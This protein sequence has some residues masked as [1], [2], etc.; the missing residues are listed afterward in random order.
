MVAGP[1]DNRLTAGQ[2]RPP[3]ASGAVTA[4]REILRLAL[5]Y[6]AAGWPV[7][8]CRPDDPSC[9]GGKDCECKAPLTE[10]GCL[11]ASTGPQV[12]RAWWRRWPAANVAIATGAP[13]PDVL[14]VD[15][16]PD[17][18]GWPAFNCLKRAGLL[19][20]A[21]A[22]VRTPSGGLH[23]Y[24]AGTS[25]RNGKLARHHLDFRSAG[26]YVL[27]PPSRVHGRPYELLDHRAADAVLDWAAVCR[28]LDTP[29]PATWAAWR[30]SPRRPSRPASPRPRRAARSHPQ[31]GGRPGEH[32]CRGHSH[33]CGA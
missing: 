11:D 28:L 7:F 2:M 1:D 15:I 31:P 20:G 3:A 25:Q 9:A 13:G 22:L 18:D 27:A 10:H 29:R 21:R 6:A 16:K 24:Y 5:A 23:S 19:A 8:P 26:G 17:G 30:T 12:I 14:D 33:L 32:R 4:P